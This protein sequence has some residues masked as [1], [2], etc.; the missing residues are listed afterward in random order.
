MRDR[1]LDAEKSQIQKVLGALA[2]HQLEAVELLRAVEPILNSN[3]AIQEKHEN[4]ITMQ[5][6]D[7]AIQLI[8]NTSS[9][10]KSVRNSIDSVS[11][12]DKKLLDDV[13]TL[14]V[15]RNSFRSGAVIR[16]P[17]TQD[18]FLATQPIDMFEP[19][20]PGRS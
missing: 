3:P 10:L 9:A 18:S 19:I 8:E 1:A 4:G 5:T 12:T 6:F 7:L 17:R 13:V 15:V 14:E 11:G 16:E 2:E 20:E